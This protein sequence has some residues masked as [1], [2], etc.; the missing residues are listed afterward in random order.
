MLAFAE[1]LRLESRPPSDPGPPLATPAPTRAAPPRPAAPILK[2]SRRR[3][4]A[5]AAI[6]GGALAALGIAR[7]SL[8]RARSPALAP[9]IVAAAPF[10]NRT[11]RRD[12]D[13]LGALAADWMIRGALAREAGTSMAIAGEAHILQERSSG[14]DTG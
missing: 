9:Q 8:S 1:R 11:G 12:L 6:A 10:E 5:P 13:D 7:G 4:I 14:D 2:S 3:W